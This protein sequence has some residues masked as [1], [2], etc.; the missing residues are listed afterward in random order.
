MKSPILLLGI[1]L[2]MTISCSHEKKNTSK[3]EIRQIVSE[4]RHSEYYSF[5]PY[6]SANLA[7][8]IIDS[9]A[10]ITMRC[11]D[12]RIKEEPYFGKC[13]D[14]EIQIAR[15]TFRFCKKHTIFSIINYPQF[16]II[17]TN[18]WDSTYAEIKRSNPDYIDPDAALYDVKNPYEAPYKY[19]IVLLNKE[20]KL[21]EINQLKDEKLIPFQDG[22]YLYRSFIHWDID[23]FDL[24]KCNDKTLLKKLIL[25]T[26]P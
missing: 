22:V 1:I 13:S 2:I 11:K 24:Y 12:G 6:F 4:F 14:D 7:T 5:L 25:K 9:T 19:S 3:E 8:I 15:K 18:L 21:K 16:S 23:Q 20:C 17:E 10:A 26:N